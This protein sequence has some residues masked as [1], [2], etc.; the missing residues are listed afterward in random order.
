MS[1]SKLETV[2]KNYEELYARR[3]PALKMFSL[4]AST[5]QHFE[6]NDEVNDEQFTDDEM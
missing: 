2:A 6:V 4:N 3:Q 1:H 5:A